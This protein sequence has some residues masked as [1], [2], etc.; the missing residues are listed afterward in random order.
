LDHSAQAFYL[1]EKSKK[2]VYKSSTIINKVNSG[3]KVNNHTANTLSKANSDQLVCKRQLMHDLNISNKLGQ[4]FPGCKNNTTCSYLHLNIES[5]SKED[6]IKTVTVM[7]SQK[8]A[9]DQP[10]ISDA[11]LVAVKDAIHKR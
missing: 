6:L 8:T 9:R 2:V 4:K 1:R 10:L 11:L 5:M 3:N 7:A